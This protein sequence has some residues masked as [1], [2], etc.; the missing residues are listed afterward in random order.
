MVLVSFGVM[1]LVFAVIY[2]VV[3]PAMAQWKAILIG[4]ASTSVL[5][6]LGRGLIELYVASGLVRS[7][8]GAGTSLVILLMWVFCS[9]HVCLL[10]AGLTKVLDRRSGAG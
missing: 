7:T 10:G 3:P 5:F 4:A 2:K 1:T 8:Y 6:T 9:S